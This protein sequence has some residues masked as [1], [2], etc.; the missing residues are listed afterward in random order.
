M[1]GNFRVN[2]TRG[3]Y[4]SEAGWRRW[5]IKAACWLMVDTWNESPTRVRWQFSFLHSWQTEAQWD[6]SRVKGAIISQKSSS[7]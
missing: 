2:Y 1:N 5:I 7:E 6:R 4:T 3:I